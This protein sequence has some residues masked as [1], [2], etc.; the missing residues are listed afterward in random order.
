VQVLTR[1]GAKLSNGSPFQFPKHQESAP[2][3]WAA[4]PLSGGHPYKASPL[5]G[6]VGPVVHL[7]D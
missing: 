4:L 6:D 3:Q 7:Q 5:C 1:F 2:K